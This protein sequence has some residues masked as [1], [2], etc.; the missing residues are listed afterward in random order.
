MSFGNFLDL[1]SADQNIHLHVYDGEV[2]EVFGIS[3][4]LLSLL[5]DCFLEDFE[6]V[7]IR[8]DPNNSNTIEIEIKAMEGK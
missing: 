2:K 5:D 1:C 6:I 4:A 7:Y 3:I 8:T